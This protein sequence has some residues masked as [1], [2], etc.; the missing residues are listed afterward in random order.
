MDE[1]IEYI[2]YVLNFHQPKLDYILK[3]DGFVIFIS[4]AKNTGKTN[5]SLLLAEYCYQQEYRTRIATN[6]KTESYMVEKQ[7]IDLETLEEWLKQEG[8]KLFILDEAGVHLKKMRFMT[9]MNLLVMDLIQL[10]RHYDAGFIAIAPSIAFI[11]SSYTNTDILDLHIHKWNQK[12]AL[13]LDNLQKSTYKLF[14]IPETTIKYKS[15]DTAIFRRKKQIDL[16]TLPL[17]CQV[18]LYYAET[19]LMKAVEAKYGIGR[20]E[21]K[22][23]LKKHILLH[24]K[25]S[26]V[27]NTC[28]DKELKENSKTFLNCHLFIIIHLI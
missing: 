7:I 3:Q 9:D 5:I 13:C 25:M 2:E 4:G 12:T 19:N 10:I 8:R 24:S 15:K 17:C 14:L 26:P 11:D 1:Q 27:T 22:R 20:E 18:S 21:I 28:V 23:L 16:S 6:I